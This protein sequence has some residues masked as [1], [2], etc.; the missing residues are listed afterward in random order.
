MTSFQVIDP[1]SI[2][3]AVSKTTL[4]TVNKPSESQCLIEFTPF[5]CPT[6]TT[7]AESVLSETAVESQSVKDILPQSTRVIFCLKQNQ[8]SGKHPKGRWNFC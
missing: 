7:T 3:T 5:Q 2:G 8:V 1:I 6:T 4:G